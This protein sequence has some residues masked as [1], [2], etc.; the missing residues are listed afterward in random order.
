MLMID[1]ERV[2]DRF[3]EVARQGSGGRHPVFRPRLPGNG[4]AGRAV[5][6]T[7]LAISALARTPP[8]DNS[9][10]VASQHVGFIIDVLL[11]ELA[12]VRGTAVVP[13]RLQATPGRVK[14]A[15]ALMK[16]RHHEK[17]SIG[18]VAAEV[19]T[20]ERAL[21]AG[22]RAAY[23]CSP[24]DLLTRIRI[25]A[26]RT[27]I[28]TGRAGAA[29]AGRMVGIPHAGRFAQCYRALVGRLPSEDMPART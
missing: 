22:I 2:T 16:A 20:S 18:A 6:E 23:Q 3:E 5:R 12:F 17:L 11:K 24:H 28:R 26:A 9:A 29:E 21:F 27:L 1:R 13:E 14:A 8:S 10:E 4:S 25:E 7:L 19:G 15:V